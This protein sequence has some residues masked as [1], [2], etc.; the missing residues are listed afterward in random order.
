MCC[1]QTLIQN[2]FSFE[3]YLLLPC[4]NWET[5]DLYQQL[6]DSQVSGCLCCGKCMAGILSLLEDLLEEF[7]FKCR[8]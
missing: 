5:V 6:Q 1:C 4:K 8:V 3:S 2:S 7:M